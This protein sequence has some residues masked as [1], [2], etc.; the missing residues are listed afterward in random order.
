MYLTQNI[1]GETD[2]MKMCKFCGTENS[3]CAIVCSSCGANE[4]KH[5]CE[6][7]GTIFDEGN[8]CPKCGVKAGTKAKKCPNCGT[9]Y[10]SIACPNCGYI[11]NAGNSSVIY[12]NTSTQPVKKRK[13]W[14]WVLGWICMFPVPLTILML[15]N[16]NLKKSIK[17]GIIVLAWAIYLIL[18][19]SGNSNK[20]TSNLDINNSGANIVPSG[21]NDSVL[22]DEEESKVVDDKVI[23]GFLNECTFDYGE[24]EHGNIRT[25]F[26]IHINGCSTELLDS[27][28]EELV[29]KVNG[30]HVDGINE[31]EVLEAFR[32]I[33]QVINGSEN[34]KALNDLIESLAQHNTDF[35]EGTIGNLN[36]RFYAF[37]ELSKSISECRM[38]ITTTKYN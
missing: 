29:I 5:K 8:F 16:Q 18:G 22:S 1:E 36:Y 23:N 30:Y 37:V 11:N 4:F 38:E 28:T 19:F 25:K 12:V 24:I 3:D 17:I 33:A 7:C 15:R 14:L 32:M 13:T 9:E 20:A 27:N 10:Y 35:Y 34:Q 26:F 31:A 6:N 21:I 2:A